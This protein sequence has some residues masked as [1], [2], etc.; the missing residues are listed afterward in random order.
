MTVYK[1][2]T[3]S[4]FIE[5]NTPN[6]VD[7][8]IDSCPLDPAMRLQ[9]LDRYYPEDD[10]YVGHRSYPDPEDA[11]E[12][13][14][15]NSDRH[16]NGGD[17][18]RRRKGGGARRRNKQRIHT[19][20]VSSLAALEHAR[21]CVSAFTV[22]GCRK[23]LACPLLASHTASLPGSVRDDPA[24]TAFASTKRGWRVFA[25]KR[26]TLRVL[27]RERTG[28]ATSVIA[29]TVDPL[30]GAG[31]ATADARA[32]TNTGPAIDVTGTRAAA[33]AATGAASPGPGVGMGAGTVRCVGTGAGA[34]AGAG[35]G[36]VAGPGAGAGVGAGASTGAEAGPSAGGHTAPGAVTVGGAGVASG[37]CAATSAGLALDAATGTAA[38]AGAGAGGG[39]GADAG[40]GAEAGACHSADAST[41]VAPHFASG[42]YIRIRA[43]H[44][45][46][47]P[48][49]DSGR[50]S[51]RPS[52]T[53]VG[54]AVGACAPIVGGPGADT[55]AARP[56]ACAGA[57]AGAGAGAGAAAPGAGGRAGAGVPVAVASTA[58]KD[59]GGATGARASRAVDGVAFASNLLPTPTTAAPLRASAHVFQPAQPFSLVA[60]PPALP[61]AAA[62]PTPPPLRSVVPL[63]THSRSAPQVS[64]P[65]AATTAPTPAPPLRSA[66]HVQPQSALTTVVPATTTAWPAPSPQPSAFASGGRAAW[67]ET[68]GTAA[69]LRAAA[70]R[71]QPAQ[72]TLRMVAH[73]HTPQP[74]CSVVRTPLPPHWW[75][76]ALAQAGGEGA[77][78]LPHTG[79]AVPPLAPAPVPPRRTGAAPPT[80]A[81]PSAAGAGPPLPQRPGH[82]VPPLA[83]APVPLRRPGAA[84]PTAA[85][86]PAGGER[87]PSLQR[88]GPAV[89]SLAP[90]LVPLR[91]IGAAAMPPARTVPIPPPPRGIAASFY[92]CARRNPQSPR[93]ST[94]APARGRCR[95]T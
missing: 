64:P 70:P 30:T 35:A 18:V 60:A 57:C 48:G 47:W 76:A 82:D 8:S 44:L 78:L 10:D 11:D 34:V 68:R 26:T 88:T 84:P 20:M 42:E 37:A 53:G 58:G 85:I 17:V 22:W 25:D 90:A 12:S 2:P 49:G 1:A 46:H 54:G 15:G 59:A 50:S 94:P 91:R 36:A 14:G 71:F 13:L 3:S 65:P 31:L 74:L 92:L 27:P 41:F 80:P 55:S 72:Q 32:A 38:R 6:Y 9:W 19:E 66:L 5:E 16:L 51:L 39:V 89:P 77:P 86:A 28:A 45:S 61:P 73:A 43:N 62:V 21:L 56:G 83:P 63:P 81:L 52:S 7:M 40:A 24:C 75:S 23:N 95:P 93:P 79:P 29:D 69:C 4:I 33:G 67:T 87:A